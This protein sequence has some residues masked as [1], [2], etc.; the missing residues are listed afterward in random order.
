MSRDKYAEGVTKNWINQKAYINS[1]HEDIFNNIAFYL[2][3]HY[4]IWS[5]ELYA[6]FVPPIEDEYQTVTFADNLIQSLVDVRVSKLIGNKPVLNVVSKDQSGKSVEQAAL[7]TNILR[8]IWY[9]RNIPTL[10][11]QA[12]LWAVV[13]NRCFLRPYWD[14]D[15]ESAS[16]DLADPLMI[17]HDDTQRSWD[18]VRSRGYVDIKSI[19]SKDAL[20]RMFPKKKASIESLP[21]VTEAGICSI[22]NKIME[23]E[24][25]ASKEARQEQYRDKTTRKAGVETIE[26]YEAPYFSKGEKNGV[27]AVIAGEQTIH[28][29][30]LPKGSNGKIP[31]V[32]MT[33]QMGFTTQWGRSL[34][35]RTRQSQKIYNMWYSKII[36]LGMLPPIYLTP[37]NSGINYDD[38]FERAYLLIDY[39]EGDAIPQI[40]Q[41]REPPNTWILILNLI[42]S[43]IEHLW[44]THEVTARASTPGG[45]D[46]S[47]R[48]IAL[49]Q[50]EDTRR[51]DSPMT[52]WT[53]SL[54]DLGDM[55]LGL[56]RENSGKKQKMYYPTV[57]GQTAPITFSKSDI[58]D[59]NSVYIEVGSEYTQ[60][61]EANMKLVTSFLGMMKFLPKTAASL[62]TPSQMHKLMGFANPGVANVFIYKNKPIQQAEDENRI[63]L[64]EDLPIP[65]VESWHIHLD[66][67]QVVREFMC[68]REFRALTS[69]R[70]KEIKEEHLLK[71]LHYFSKSVGN[72]L[73]PEYAAMMIKEPKM[74]FEQSTGE[75][76][77]EETQ[78]DRSAEA[79]AREF[80]GE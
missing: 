5:S 40:I 11:I 52:R 37:R 33:D 25:K 30:G 50:K 7:E 58:T 68:S 64:D 69:D 34:V 73:P 57:G 46:M 21:E 27:Y 36:E 65:K 6:Y 28:K 1:R 10:L 31:V 42:R 63:M 41:P 43:S 38:L 60:N 13:G 79:E 20:I 23:L 72:Q 47:G 17:L 45:K 16:I 71:H 77:P 67:L 48:G 49:L 80:G 54:Q 74:P 19:Q 56:Y 70:Q 15:T 78:I 44:G 2:G 14:A 26:R 8:A 62:D 24:D 59:K 75:P 61:R 66:H 22:H 29:K 9:D 53:D 55:L 51:L 3:Y 76:T 12:A 32:N 35:S 4:Q 39:D 18:K